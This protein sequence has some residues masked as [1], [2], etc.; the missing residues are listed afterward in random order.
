LSP[1]PHQPKGNIQGSYGARLGKVLEP[2]IQP[3]GFDWRIGVGLVGAFAAREVFVSTMALVYGMGAESVV[4]RETR[5]LKWP[6]FLFGYTVVLAWLMSF[7][8][9]QIGGMR[10][11]G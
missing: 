5:S 11:L 2:V 9:C 10:G 7:L 6:A 4:R 1:P 8:V 3:L